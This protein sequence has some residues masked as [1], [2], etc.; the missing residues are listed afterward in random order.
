MGKVSLRHV[1][2]IFESENKGKKRYV[3]AVKDFSMEIEDN[4]FIVFV[5]PSGCGKST[6]LR[7]IAGLEDI[8][9]GEIYIDDLLINELEPKDRNIAMVF[10]NYALYPHMTAYKNIAFSLRLRKIPV[11]KL[12]ESGKEILAIDNKKIRS[13]KREI[14]RLEKT[15]KRVNTEDKSL[16]EHE[17]D[18]YKKKLD[19]F[20]NTPVPVYEYKHMSK[21]ELDRRVRHAAKILDIESLLDR[22]PREMSGG[23]RQR[24][25]LGRAIVRNPKVF[26]LDEPLSNLDAKLRAQMRAEITSLHNRLKTT[27]IYVTH[28]QIEAMTMGTRIVVMKDGIIQ[29]IDTPNNLFNHPK[30]VFVAGFIGTPQMNFFKGDFCY[31]NKQNQIILEN[32]VT[33]K[34]SAKD[35]IDIK[36]EYLDGKKHKI[37]LGVRG[38]DVLPNEDGFT[39]KTGIKENLGNQTHVYFN[40]G[41]EEFNTNRQFIMVLSSKNEHEI[42]KEFK[43]SFDSKHIHL[44]DADTEESLEDSNKNI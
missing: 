4:E 17:L 32:G 26:L 1:Y 5:G 21:E 27:F 36:K 31:K 12:D 25:A 33:L 30:N 44:F 7:M 41:N 40:L 9:K 37:I 13:L 38:E 20:M 43:I 15:M 14:A 16:V 24:I 6:T 39:V 35:M 10:Q 42:G 22:K 29:Q 18:S 23:Q 8:S 11:A 34:Y 28:D 2:K 3:E 19:Y